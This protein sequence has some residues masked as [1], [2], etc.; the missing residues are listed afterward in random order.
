MGDSAGNNIFAA[1][2]GCHRRHLQRLQVRHH[3]LTS[4]VLA[5]IADMGSVLCRTPSAH[6]KWDS[7]AETDEPS[8]RSAIPQIP[9]MLN[10]FIYL[11]SGKTV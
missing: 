1:P 4:I 6:S 5:G 9:S 10:T 2:P 7:Y 3:A 11:G 8:T